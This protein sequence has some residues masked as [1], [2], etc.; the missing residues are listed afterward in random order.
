MKHI[1]LYDSL[2]GN[3]KELADCIK[4]ELKEAYDEKIDNETLENIPN[5]DIYYIGTPIIKGTCTDKIQKI[6]EKLEKKKIF[7]FVTAGFGGSV[8]YFASLEKRIKSYIPKSS[9]VIGTFFCQGKMPDQAK[10]KYIKLI[11]EHPEDKKLKVSLQN[12][13]EAKNHPN[14]K[15][16]E[17][18]IKK[19]KEIN[20]K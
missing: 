10:E 12:F 17:N 2:T 7:L 4:Q 15:D 16:K 14:N 9:K 20:L 5:G 19:I 11:K 1:I 3:T 8:D 6:L 13:E 18:L